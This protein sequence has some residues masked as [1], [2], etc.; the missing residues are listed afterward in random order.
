MEPK[1]IAKWL[2]ITVLGLS[3]VTG[4]LFAVGVLGIP[5]GGLEDNEWGAVEDDRIEVIT[6][7]WV[8]NPNPVGIGGDTD[9]EY[10]VALEGVELAAGEGE[11]LGIDS[12]TNELELR[13]DLRQQRLPAWWSAHLNNDEVSN[14]R[15]DATIH[16]SVGPF[17]GSP[18]HTHTDEIGTDIEGA[19]D[20]GFSEFEGEYTAS[21]VVLDGPSSVR[22]EPGVE[23]RN[24]TTRWGTVT[25]QRTEIILTLD[26][27]NPNAHPLPTPAFVGEM[28]ANNET[29][30]NWSASDVE[31][32]NAT[33]DAIIPPQSAERRVLVVEMDN[34]A[35]PPWFT[36]HVDREEFSDIAI[37]GQLA[38][39]ISGE[40]IT[41]PA[42]GDAVRCE[43][44]LRTSIFVDQEDGLER[45]FCGP[46]PVETAGDEL[47]MTTEEIEGGGGGIEIDETDLTD[48]STDD[49]SSD[50]D[51]DESPDVDGPDDDDSDDGSLLA[52]GVGRER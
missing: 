15:V 3:V 20:E 14:L 27:Y 26:I 42:E 28:T 48:G 22:G 12:G 43:F 4:G 40:Q 38:M 11:G 23:I 50:G 33:G 34:R 6:T 2:G 49:G 10:E 31:V 35:V 46:T 9:V 13:T 45:G 37:T 8:D 21:G 5:D 39:S 44:D 24:A 19:L 41:I 1:R 51:S 25:E 52:L 17:S 36:T 47:G 18:E 29:L 7:V 30:A 16:T 32:R